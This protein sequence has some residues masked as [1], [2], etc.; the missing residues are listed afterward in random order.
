MRKTDYPSTLKGIRNAG[1]I[2]DLR[3]DCWWASSK[4]C[5]SEPYFSLCFSFVTKLVKNQMQFV[6]LFIIF[7]FCFLFVSLYLFYLFIYL[8]V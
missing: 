7:V 5:G 2:A 1:Y 6:Q 3:P 4:H 8:S